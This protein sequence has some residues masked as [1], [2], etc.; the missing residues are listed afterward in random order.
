MGGCRINPFDS[1]AKFFLGVLEQKTVQN[2]LK[3]LFELIASGLFTFLFICGGALGAC[4]VA[5]VAPAYCWISAVG[6]GMVSAAISMTVVFR[7]SPLTKGMLLVLP[8]AEAAKGL[9]TDLQTIE[10]K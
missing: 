1:I 5:K 4:V 2:W 6:S 9:A 8:S 7:R 3:L 10:R